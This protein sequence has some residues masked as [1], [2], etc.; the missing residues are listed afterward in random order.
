MSI[1][2]LLKTARTGA[3]LTGA[4]LS[5]SGQQQMFASLLTAPGALTVLQ[6]TVPES[7]AATQTAATDGPVLF[8]L[9][10]AFVML[11]LFLH[12]LIGVREEHHGNVH[13]TVKP[14]KS[15]VPKWFWIEM[16]I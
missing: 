1:N 16:R 12:A 15:R 11:G 13:I 14:A 2:T 8:V 4:I 3:I 6:G 5:F 10:I 9:G 7:A